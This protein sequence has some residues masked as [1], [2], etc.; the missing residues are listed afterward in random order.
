MPR[1]HA[2]SYLPILAA[3]PLLFVGACSGLRTHT[4]TSEEILKREHP[5][6]SIFG[7]DSGL[8]IVGGTKR[9]SDAES[10]SGVGVNDLLWR[11]SLDTLSFL[12]LPI[13]PDP[14]GGVIVYDWYT[15]QETPN[16]RYKVNVFILDRQLRADG[17]RVSVFRQIRDGSNWR[18]TGADTETSAKL[19]DAILTRARQMRSAQT[20]AG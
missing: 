1:R 7:G 14:F 5:S 2:K 19:E 11:A 16:E 18:D 13:P 10:S 3:L 20:N 6:G 12:P 9:R 8:D 4:E 15:P 17:V